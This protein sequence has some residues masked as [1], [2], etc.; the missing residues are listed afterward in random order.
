M[1]LATLFMLSVLGL[2]LFCLIKACVNNNPEDCVH[3][4]EKKS[5]SRFK[6][7]KCGMEF[8]L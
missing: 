3:L 8:Y 1:S 7:I 4:Y 5:D 6:C 2:M